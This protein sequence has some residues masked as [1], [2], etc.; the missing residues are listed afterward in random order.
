MEITLKRRQW[1]PLKEMDSALV[2]NTSKHGGQAA[3]PVAELRQAVQGV[4]ATAEETCGAEALEPGLERTLAILQRNPDFRGQFESQLIAL[5]D[6]PEEGV[7]EVVSFLM[8]VLR[9]EAV[10]EAVEERVNYPR[11]NVSSIRLYEAM[12]DSFSDFWR[13]RDLYARF[14]ES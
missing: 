8:H 14:A 13:D 12:L 6:S 10:R 1:M 7:V 3:D 4:L 9:W 11:G 5:I 2:E